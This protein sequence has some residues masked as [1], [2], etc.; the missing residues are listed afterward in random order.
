VALGLLELHN[1]AEMVMHLVS[2]C[3]CWW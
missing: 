3:W 1:R 2:W